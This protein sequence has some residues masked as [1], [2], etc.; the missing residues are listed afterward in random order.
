MEKTTLFP[1]PVPSR[2]T[3][4]AVSTLR[5]ADRLFG[6]LGSGEA[7]GL[8]FDFLHPGS[9]KEVEIVLTFVVGKGAAVAGITDQTRIGDVSQ[10]QNPVF[11]LRA[12]HRLL[13]RRFMRLFELGDAAI[14]GSH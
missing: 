1:V 12:H 13:G 3:V 9:S 7:A 11:F 5:P 10:S 6:V 8:I 14:L 4:P 2:A